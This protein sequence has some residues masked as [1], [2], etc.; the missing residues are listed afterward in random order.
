MDLQLRILILEDK[1]EDLEQILLQLSK[2]AF[3]YQYIH[4]FDKVGFEK[5]LASFKPDIILSN[6][7]LLNLSSLEA[8]IIAQSFDSD[9]PFILI[10]EE[11]S[12]S[13]AVDLIVKK[14]VNDYILKE[15]FERLNPSILREIRNY[16]LRK[17]L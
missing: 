15:H 9:T 12:E 10:S 7:H 6:H 1:L 14:G 8:Y 4:C 2:G 16:H 5:G 3:E 17:E 13:E 11:L